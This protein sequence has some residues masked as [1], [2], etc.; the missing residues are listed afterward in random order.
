MAKRDN[1]RCFDIWSFIADAILY[2][3]SPAL[4]DLVKK[5]PWN[6][7]EGWLIPVT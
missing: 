7:V 2:S 6:G 1:L 5:V 4:E 3:S